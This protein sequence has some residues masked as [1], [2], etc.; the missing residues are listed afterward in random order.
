MYASRE[1]HYSIFK[2]ARMYRMDSVKVDT[3]ETGEIDYEQLKQHLEANKA[4]PAIINVN[5]GT[6]V[7]GAVDDLD[8]ILDILAETGY[9]ED[10][11]GPAA[12]PAA[13]PADAH[14]ALLWQ[15]WCS[16]IMQNKMYVRAGC[17][18]GICACGWVAL[19]L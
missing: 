16:L 8:R 3:M 15:Q 12:G 6:T 1:T 9:T 11:W 4:R 14:V 17:W 18:H 10:R 13:G 7:K 19:P 5:I 2:A